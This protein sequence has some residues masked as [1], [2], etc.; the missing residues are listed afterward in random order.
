MPDEFVKVARV[1]LLHIRDQLVKT[2]ELVKK[3]ER[4]ESENSVLHRVLGLI[5]DGVIDSSAAMEKIADFIQDPDNLRI[6]EV[7]M[8][9]GAREVTKLGAAIDDGTADTS[10]TGTPEDRFSQN[11]M[12]IKSGYAY[13]S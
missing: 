5:A 11:L 6:F 9:S 1:D 8:A 10:A 13:G 2:A 4:L 3:A 7:A 12:N